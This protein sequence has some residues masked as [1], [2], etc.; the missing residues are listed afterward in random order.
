MPID[1]TARALALGVLFGT[2][3]AMVPMSALA[4]YVDAASGHQRSHPLVSLA[5]LVSVLLLA[6]VTYVV[7]PAGLWTTT[8][9][10]R[11]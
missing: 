11:R 4:W 10:T 8:K 1:K 7:Q 3:A 6:T 9:A 5:V 2:T